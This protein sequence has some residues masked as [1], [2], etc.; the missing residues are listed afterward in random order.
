[1]KR[2]IP[3][4]DSIE[5]L[6]KFWDTHD[7]TDFEDELEEVTGP[8]FVRGCPATVTVRLGP[9]EREAVERIA[10]RKGVTSVGL[11]HTWLRDKIR[12]QTKGKSNNT[13]GVKKR[14]KR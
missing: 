1:M 8:I 2:K 12:Q 10:R 5:E 11:L 3:R 9:K 4:I 7:L 13:A 14:A 6:A